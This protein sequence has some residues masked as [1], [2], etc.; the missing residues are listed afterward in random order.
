[1]EFRITFGTRFAHDIMEY[2]SRYS[3]SQN[4]LATASQIYSSG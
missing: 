3:I 2:G 1:M 4:S